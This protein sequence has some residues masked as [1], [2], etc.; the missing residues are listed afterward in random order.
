MNFV[1]ALVLVLIIIHLLSLFSILPL[2]TK[3]VISP[4]CFKTCKLS[5]QSPA[6]RQVA[7][8]DPVQEL[9]ASGTVEVVSSRRAEVLDSKR[10]RG[11]S[12]T[13]PAASTHEGQAAAIGRVDHGPAQ[14]S[15]SSLK[16][17]LSKPAKPETSPETS[18][19]PLLLGRELHE[20]KAPHPHAGAVTPSDMIQA[21]ETAAL[22][23]RL[24]RILEA[25]YRD[26]NFRARDISDQL[27]MSPRTLQRKLSEAGQS[28]PKVFL[29]EMRLLKAA[30]ALATGEKPSQVAFDVG[31]SSH[32]YF[33]RCFK[34]RYGMPPSAYESNDKA[35]R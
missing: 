21:A 34:A 5:F 11:L 2:M 1:I 33:S 13:D 15:D 24:L 23:E 6:Q 25:N 10:F 22:M 27:A 16:S 29:Q 12:A 14:V 18:V 19:Q 7:V 30:E 8:R 26:P 31:F 4:R 20:T 17:C 3:T 9:Q 35:G 32:S 28:S